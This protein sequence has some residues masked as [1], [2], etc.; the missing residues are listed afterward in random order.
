MYIYIYYIYL[1]IYMYIYIYIHIYYIKLRVWGVKSD[2]IK[3]KEAITGDWQVTDVGNFF[4]N[5]MLFVLL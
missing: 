1:Y 5:M 4:A 3:G 2:S